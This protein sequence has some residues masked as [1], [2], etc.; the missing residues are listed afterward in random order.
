MLEI[1]ILGFFGLAILRV[2]FA[3]LLGRSVANTVVARLGYEL[4]RLP[5][6]VLGGMFRLAA[7]ALRDVRPRGG[8]V[9]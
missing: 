9:R 8:T 3:T 1:L 6:R 5:F 7:W 4:L 2:A